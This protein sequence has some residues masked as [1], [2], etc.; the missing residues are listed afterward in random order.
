MQKANS[1]Q[2]KLP[3]RA[4]C[5]GV[6]SAFAPWALLLLV[7][8]ESCFGGAHLVEEAVRRDRGRK[9]WSQWPA[10]E[11]GGRVGVWCSGQ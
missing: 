7:Q 8:L 6:S 3:T 10:W 4:P 2:V 9:G 1:N 5:V 11:P